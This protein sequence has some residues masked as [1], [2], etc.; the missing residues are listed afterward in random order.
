MEEENWFFQLSAFEERLLDYYDAHP[1]FVTP[2][3]KR[4][5]ALAF[6]KGGLRDISITRT[7][8]TWGVP[9]PWDE[10]PRLL[11]LVRRADQLPDGR[12]ATGATT[13]RCAALVAA[14]AP[15]D[16]Q[17][18]HPLPLR[19]VAR[20]V[21]GGRTRAA[22]HVHVHGWLL[23][24][25]EKLGKTMSPRAGRSRGPRPLKI[26]DIAPIALTDE[27]G[28]DPLRYYLLRETP[29]GN[30][31]DFSYEGIV[32]RYNT[33]LANNLGN[34][35][36]RVTTV[37]HSKC[38]GVGPAPN[39]ASGL[40]SVAAGVLASATA[41]WD[42]FAPHEALEATWRLIGAA[43]AELEAAEP[44]KMEP[45][46]DVDAVLGDALEV[47]RIVAVLIAPAMPSTAAE[48]W[49]RI[50]VPGE[51]SAARLPADAGWG[52]YTG[53]AAVVKG[54]PLFPRRKA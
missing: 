5:E 11:R 20:D 32:A 3:T 14:L 4:N 48:V 50:G 41:A 16:R 13:T 34:L 37:V 24:G 25:G 36:A 47:L 43:N 30:D 42:R 51:P 15:P 9:V 12:S 45:G 1:G 44:W 27:F 35:V 49:R 28:V 2:E 31:G 18:D 10:R 21:H 29:L 40:A 38:E 54:E 22:H 19:L 39:P 46:P 23:V 7:S 26:T 17:G 53:G 33:D 6:I 52:G 8:I